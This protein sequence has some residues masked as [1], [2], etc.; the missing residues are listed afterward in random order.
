V[1]EHIIAYEDY[2]FEFG[3][4]VYVLK[5]LSMVRSIIMYIV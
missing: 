3:S 5:V 4:K 1:V 2:W